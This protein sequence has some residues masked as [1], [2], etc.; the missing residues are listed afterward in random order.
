MCRCGPWPSRAA[1]DMR[2]FSGELKAD[3]RSFKDL[4]LL[5]E[6]KLE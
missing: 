4:E 2:Q 6:G 1:G 5:E 3:F